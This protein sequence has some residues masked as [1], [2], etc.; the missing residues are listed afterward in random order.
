MRK[1][2]QA[3]NDGHIEDGPDAKMRGVK[4]EHG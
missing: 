4:E 3:G 2:K 1:A